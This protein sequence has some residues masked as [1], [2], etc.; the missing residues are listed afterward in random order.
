ME[1][2]TYQE[3]E[4]IINGDKIL[5][6]FGNDDDEKLLIKPFSMWTEVLGM[7]YHQFSY[8]NDI[9]SMVGR[10]GEKQKIKE[11]LNAEE[12]FKVN[13]ITGRAGS[14]KSRLVYYTFKDEEIKRNWSIYGLSY[15]ELLYFKY[16]YI[17]T[18]V[19]KKTIKK[20]ILFVIDY[21]TINAEQIGKWIKKLYLNC[22]RDQRDI[23]IRIL[24]VERAH[25]RE[26]RKPYWYIR[27][28]EGNKLDDYGLCN[29]NEHFQIHNLRDNELSKIFTEYVRKNKERY[30]KN[31]DIDPDYSLCEAE[32]DKIIDSLE[33]EC[34]TPLYIMYMA[35]A[36]IDDIN[37]KGRN[38][39]REES[40]EYV[41]K[42][43]DE[44]I[45]GFFS[46]GNVKEKEAALKK[47][48][49]YSVALDGVK[50]GKKLPK[51]LEKEFE[52]IREEFGDGS[53]NLRHLFNEVG[54][55]ETSKEIT[56]K[57][58]LPEIA[59][60]FYCLRYLQNISINIF[61]DNTCI[62]QFVQCA[63][64]ENPRAF[65]AFLCRIIEDFPDHKLVDFSGVLG[66]P[67][68]HNT[69]SKVIY[70]D[71]LREYTYWNKEILNCFDTVIKYFETLIAGEPCKEACIEIYEKYSIALL[72]I[73]WWCKQEQQCK[74]IDDCVNMISNKMEIICGKVS[75]VIICQVCYAIK[76]VIKEDEKIK[77]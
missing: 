68:F 58:V 54:K 62:N 21:V 12:H 24:L 75:D 25:V 27:L 38:W 73:V 28:V 29:Y 10:D 31:Y 7:S 59:G 1:Q 50:L 41:A 17:C 9:I 70:A 39:S 51:F 20:K 42:K 35:D 45:K 49:V 5:I 4:T 63:W 30:N 71:L 36:W 43:E 66:M 74:I 16:Q 18:M 23:Y 53:P 33:K 8:R 72:N 37:K 76:K 65:A 6:F 61:F 55:L 64:E 69:E 56:L 67:S 32:A 44:R 46:R 47:I 14:G 52:V 57:S 13:A 34:K 19:E 3:A 11:F 48:M 22:I 40:L 2:S 60:E 77:C 26:D 15:E